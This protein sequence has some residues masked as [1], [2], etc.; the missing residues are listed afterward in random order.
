M[1]FGCLPFGRLRPY[2]R[3]RPDRQEQDDHDDLPAED[4]LVDV[5]PRDAAD[6]LAL[7]SYTPAG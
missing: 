3:D 7:I 1:P 2:V 4:D 6:G 5:D